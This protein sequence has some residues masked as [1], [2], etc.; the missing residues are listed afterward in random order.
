ML[1]K[2][3][4]LVGAEGS[5]AAEIWKPIEGF[6]HHVISNLGRIKSWHG[7]SRFIGNG[8]NFKG[9]RNV[10]LNAG[11]KKHLVHRLVLETF[12]G[13]CPP[14]CE[15]NH[16]NGIKTN[17][18]LSNLEW[19]PPGVNQAHAYKIGLR[20]SVGIFNSRAKLKDKDIIE[21]RSLDTKNISHT[22][23]AKMFKISHSHANNIIH[24]RTWKH[25]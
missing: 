21:I 14:G 10:Q 3:Q 13:P 11:G 20:S 22:I 17:C 12:V 15:A 1:N 9:Y 8:L 7:P 19:V 18:K 6:P 4:I 2:Q 25:I 24:R 23:I 16:K 5:P